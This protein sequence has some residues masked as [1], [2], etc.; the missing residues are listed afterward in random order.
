MGASPRNRVDN[1]G[2]IDEQGGN[3]IVTLKAGSTITGNLDGGR[4]T[5]LLDLSAAAGSSDSLPSVVK[6]SIRSTR[7]ALERRR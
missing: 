1:F 4:G 2:T 7:L 3:D 6:T 5:N